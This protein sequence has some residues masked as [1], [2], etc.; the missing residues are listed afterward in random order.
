MKTTKKSSVRPAKTF[1]TRTQKKQLASLGERWQLDDKQNKLSA[2]FTLATSLDALMFVTKIAIFFEVNKS[3]GDLQLSE[4]NVKV[5]LKCS[6]DHTSF[7]TCCG[8][9]TRIN[10]LLS[11][12]RP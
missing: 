1:L 2:S 11:T 9:A 5:T 7:D 6:Q 4:K 12:R 10:T 3:Y 8:L